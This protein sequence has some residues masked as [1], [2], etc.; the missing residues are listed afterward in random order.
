MLRYVITRPFSAPYDV[1]LFVSIGFIF[2][3]FL[4]TFA[5]V[6]PIITL[7]I[8]L[9]GAWMELF[10]TKRFDRLITVVVLLILTNLSPALGWIIFAF[11]FA[12]VFGPTAGIISAPPPFMMGFVTFIS[13]TFLP[14]PILK[15]VIHI[16]RI[17]LNFFG[18]L[19]TLFFYDTT[20][21]L[22]AENGFTAAL[23]ATPTF[24]RSFYSLFSFYNVVELIPF[25]VP[26]LALIGAVALAIIVLQAFFAILALG[27]GCC[28]LIFTFCIGLRNTRTAQ[29]VDDME[30]EYGSRLDALEHDDDIL[31]QQ[32][33]K[34][35][36][37]SATAMTPTSAQESL[38]DRKRK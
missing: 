36:A 20:P 6:S 19:S 10:H 29:K 24:A 21:L 22:A 31:M 25:I 28:G 14:G 7:S 5:V 35:P 16:L 3:E 37:A 23:T 26:I 17:V 30:E 34:S 12:A 15:F 2:L 8:L 4:N 32:A 38:E 18:G 11:F 13:R 27:C 1:L 9:F 33:A